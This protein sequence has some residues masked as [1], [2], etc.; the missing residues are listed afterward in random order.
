MSTKAH[1]P[2]NTTHISTTAKIMGD[3]WTP[4]IL[5][6]LSE[7]SMRFCE[8]EAAASGIS[9]RTLSARLDCLERDGIISRAVYAEVPPRVQYTLTAKGVDLLPIVQSMIRWA[10]KYDQPHQTIA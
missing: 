10:E 4:I 6:A 3:K 1:C 9:P 8:I 5:F 7:Q 2:Q